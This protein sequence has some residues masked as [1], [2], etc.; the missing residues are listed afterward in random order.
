MSVPLTALD[1]GRSGSGTASGASPGP[2]PQREVGRRADRDPHPVLLD[3]DLADA[4]LLHDPHD[5]LDSLGAV[6]PHAGELVVAPSTAADPAQQLLG[7]LAEEPEQE[8]LLLARRDVARALAHLVE[9]RRDVLLA[10]GV[11]GELDDALESRVDRRR[12]RAE[13]AGDETAH[14]VHDDEI[15]ARRK[16]VDDR[17]RRE[18]LADRRRE[19]R[20]SRLGADPVE[21]LEHFV[22]PVRGAL[23]LQRLVDPGDDARRQVVTRREH[24]DARR[25]RSHELVADVLVE[26]VCRLPQR[27]DVDAG[28]QARC[29]SA[30][31]RA[32]HRRPG[33]A[34]AQADRSRTR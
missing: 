28:V 30:P 1:G 33:G 22:E 24:G 25:Q 4:R 23:R 34:S 21:L 27:V 14:L 3:R 6:L 10:L 7:V 5:L 11:G 8:Q 20:P 12:R 2:V 29:R 15:A 19:R 18:H 16:D 31:R 17:L 13:R 26:D 32:P 9:R